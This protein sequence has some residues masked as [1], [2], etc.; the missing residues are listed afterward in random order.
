MTFD[1]AAQAIKVGATVSRLDWE[2]M[3]KAVIL[4]DALLVLLSD[5]EEDN[6][7]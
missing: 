5:D 3:D 6:E 2:D 1:D 7:D 4:E